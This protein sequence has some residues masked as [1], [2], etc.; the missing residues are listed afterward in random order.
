VLALTAAELPDGTSLKTPGSNSYRPLPRNG[1]PPR[2][3]EPKGPI[4]LWG[5]NTLGFVLKT[6]Q[7]GRTL[8]LLV[9]RVVNLLLVG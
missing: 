6:L 1:T 7:L 3:R 9:S 2:S 8:G 4:G 5:T